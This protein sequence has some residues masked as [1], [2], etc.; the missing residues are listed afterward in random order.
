M[1][2][3]GL[4][5]KVKNKPFYEPGF[6]PAYKFIEAYLKGASQPY[7]LAW[8]RKDYISKF[9][10][11][12]YGT[13]EKSELDYYY[14]KLITEFTYNI[15]GGWKLYL[16]GD[17]ALSLKIKA[18]MLDTL[19]KFGSW[20]SIKLLFNQDFTVEFLPFEQCPQNEGSKPFGNHLNGCRIGFDGGGSDRKVSAVIDG[21]V[22]YSEEVLWEA[23][24]RSDIDYHYNEVLTAFKTA[25]AKMPRV[26][27]IGVSIAGSMVGDQY[28]R[29]TI[30]KEVSAKDM[31]EKG[32]DLF[33]RA[34]DQ[35]GPNI[36]VVGRNDG[37]I[38]ALAGAMSLQ[39]NKLWGV[40]LGTGFGSGY[41]D[42]AGNLKDWST[43]MAF[44]KV[45][46]NED[47]HSSELLGF[48][49]IGESYISQN[50]VIE[51]A[52]KE[53]IEMPPEL[54]PAEK[55]LIIQDYMNKGD[56]RTTRIFTYMG[57]CFAHMLP[58]AD[59]FLD[60]E[61]VYLIGRL[62]SGKGGEVFVQE[63]QRVL[64]EDYPDHA[65]KMTLWLPDENDRR[66]SQS[67]AAASLPIVE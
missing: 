53:G 47:A 67:V 52:E 23:K 38:A 42:G 46:V 13:P 30:T 7:A 1:E 61:H 34:A 66:V 63:C 25:A 33:R 57:C 58:L 11:F 41:V 12:I 17:E 56:S 64:N 8:Q 49:G 28:Y 59:L 21:E 14:L 16:C 32:R 20:G 19:A 60:I 35:I 55:L 39:K 51:M 31:E 50:R 29:G 27:A 10:T 40:P 2:F 43:N 5:I 62:V 26:D 48:I 24:F 9:S 65:A 15:W 18:A 22:V 3:M 54:Y 6:I 4:D 45:A 36:P 44:S 37:D